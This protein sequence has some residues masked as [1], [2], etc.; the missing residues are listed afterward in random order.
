MTS[1]KTSIQNIWLFADDCV[2]Y[3]DINLKL[4]CL[5]LQYLQKLVDWSNTWQMSF[6][7]NNCHTLHAH[8][9]KQPIIHTYTTDNTTVRNTSY[10]PPIYWHRATIRPKMDNTHTKHNQLSTEDT[11]HAE[12]KPQTPST[13]LKSQAYKTI[14]RPKLEYASYIWDPHTAKDMYNL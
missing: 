1:T 13:T 6:N 11:K 9:K 7:I 5:K 3:R 12:K 8:R 14:V 2:L 4:D 10:A